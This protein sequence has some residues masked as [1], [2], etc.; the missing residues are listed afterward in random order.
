MV[1]SQTLARK[2]QIDRFTFTTCSPSSSFLHFGEGISLHFSIGNKR[3]RKD[4]S[5]VSSLPGDKKGDS[6]QFLLESSELQEKRR[7]KGGFAL[8]ISKSFLTLVEKRKQAG[9]DVYLEFMQKMK[10]KKEYYTP[11]KGVVQGATNS[12]FVDSRTGFCHYLEK[13]RI[14]PGYESGTYREDNTVLLTFPEH[15]HA[16]YL[17]FLQ[18]GKVADRVAVNKMLGQNTA[19]TRRDMAQY[20]GS[21]GGKQQQQNLRDQNRG[22]YNSEV[23]RKLGKKGAAVAKERGVGAFDPQNLLNALAAWQTKFQQDTAFRQKMVNNLKQGLKTQAQ[24]GMNIYNPASQR[25]RVIN[26]KGL[27]IDGKIVFS[28]YSIV[29]TDETFEYSEHRVHMSEDLYWNH[30]KNRPVGK[31]VNYRNPKPSNKNL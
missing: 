18:Y 6:R 9:R 5:C 3:S 4:N 23:Q 20:A 29:Y 19:Q 24:R 15:V 26:G 16:H 7:K 22:W 13:H 21:L 1:L 28:S 30:I 31:R 11:A 25:H 17:R 10:Q 2:K 27:S 12:D 8:P 14:L